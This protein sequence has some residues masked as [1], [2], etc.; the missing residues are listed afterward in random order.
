MSFGVHARRPPCQLNTK[1]FLFFVPA[2]ADLAVV[3]RSV[4]LDFALVSTRIEDDS[5]FA[6]ERLKRRLH[7]LLTL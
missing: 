3:C 6:A 4:V 1:Y 7:L 2:S 5:S